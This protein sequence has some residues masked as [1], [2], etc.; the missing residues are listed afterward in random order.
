MS[1]RT[2]NPFPKHIIASGPSINADGL[3]RT[4]E[5][6]FMNED[7]EMPDISRH[8][9][10]FEEYAHEQHHDVNVIRTEDYIFNQFILVVKRHEVDC[11]TIYLNI[12]IFRC[13]ADLNRV[14]MT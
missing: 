9:Y 8:P 1:V 12:A 4:L 6:D 10:W 11:M 7:P 14:S 2:S 5:I 3:G 13:I